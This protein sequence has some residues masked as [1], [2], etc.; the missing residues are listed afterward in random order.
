MRPMS[1]PGARVPNARVID[2]HDRNASTV[3][4]RCPSTACTSAVNTD[5]VAPRRGIRAVAEMFPDKAIKLGE[6]T[7]GDDADGMGEF[8]DRRV[9]KPVVDEEALLSA[10]DQAGFPKR[11]QVLRGVGERQ[12]CLPGERID[13]T[14]ALRQQLEELEAVRAGEALAD[15]GELSVEAV[16]EG[17]VCGVVIHSQEIY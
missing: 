13:G 2:A 10:L 14:L 5:P 17:A 16:F 4:T 1:G 8:E 6:P 3:V 11:E 12:A 9:R 7:F 15:A